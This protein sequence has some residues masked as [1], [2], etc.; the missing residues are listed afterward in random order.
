MVNEYVGAGFPL[1]FT[2]YEYNCPTE[3]DVTAVD[4]ITGAVFCIAPVL[5]TLKF[6]NTIFGILLLYLSG[7]LPRWILK[8]TGNHGH[9]DVTGYGELSVIGTPISK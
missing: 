5:T 4:V 7:P 9:G 3:P 2:S 6:L 8:S 1:A